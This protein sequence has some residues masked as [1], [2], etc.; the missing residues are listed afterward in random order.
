[1][2][3]LHQ[4]VSPDT[5]GLPGSVEPS[6]SGGRQRG[7]NKTGTEKCSICGVL[8]TVKNFELE[9][10]ELLSQR[11]ILNEEGGGNAFGSLE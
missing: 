4:N 10:Y 7:K 1:M 6:K 9:S 2:V 5:T 3:G 8:D 11:R